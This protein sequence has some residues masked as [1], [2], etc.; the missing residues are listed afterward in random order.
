MLASTSPTPPEGSSAKTSRPAR[1]PRS[2][3]ARSSDAWSTTSAREVLMKMVPGFIE[4]N[5]PSPMRPR[6]SGTSARWTVRMSA[7]A[8]TSVGL[9]SSVMFSSSALAGRRC[10]SHAMAR[11]PNACAR[12]MTSIPMVPAPITPSVRPKSPRACAYRFLFHLPLF[13]S[14]VPS[15][16]CRSRASIRPVASSAT[17]M[18][19]LPGQFAT[20]MPRSLAASTSMVLVPAPARTTSWRFPDS[21]IGRVTCE[22]RTTRTSAP[23]LFTAASR[24]SPETSGS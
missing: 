24:L 4:A 19:F 13:R 21:S 2:L 3:T 15:A 6:V 23:V 17:A 1:I 11:I 18:A 22:E 16:M 12:L 7:A 14:A 10:L 8:A 20:Q 5:T 9:S